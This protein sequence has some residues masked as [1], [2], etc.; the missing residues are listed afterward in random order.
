MSF[1][2]YLSRKPESRNL[3]YEQLQ[4]KYEPKILK[5][6]NDYAAR[7]AR[8]L[9]GPMDRDD[10]IQVACIAFWE[11]NIRFDLNVVASGRN[12]EKVFIAFADSLIRGRLSDHLRKLSRRTSCELL[13]SSKEAPD[14]SDSSCES[15]EEQM[16]Q[17]VT[18]YLD[19]LSPRE[20][21]YLILSVIK[22][23]STGDIA[24]ATAVSEHTVRSWKKS[25]RKKMQGLK[26]IL[27]HHN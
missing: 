16:L 8:H 14:F 5:A 21:Q 9:R 15:I 19:R 20:R 2:D 17:L 13:H 26:D 23:W 10:L 7:Y 6:V 22:G 18:D 12:P 25:M 3:A 11:A 24:R 27:Q 4:K 1:I